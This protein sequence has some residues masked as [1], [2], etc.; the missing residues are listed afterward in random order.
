[1]CLQGQETAKFKDYFIW[2]SAEPNKSLSNQQEWEQGSM[3]NGGNS[4]PE[5]DSL[6]DLKEL[7]GMQSL[8]GSPRTPLSVQQSSPESCELMLCPQASPQGSAAGE[9]PLQMAAMSQRV[10]Y[11]GDFEPTPDQDSLKICTASHANL[12]DTASEGRI[13][14]PWPCRAAAG[15]A[16]ASCKIYAVSHQDVPYGQ[17]VPPVR[18]RKFGECGTVRERLEASDDNAGPLPLCQTATGQGTGKPSDIGMVNLQMIYESLSEP[19]QDDSLKGHSSDQPILHTAAINVNET[20]PSMVSNPAS[21]V[22]ECM[23]TRNQ[24]VQYEDD[25]DPPTEKDLQDCSKDR[26]ALQAAATQDMAFQPVGPDDA[27]TE[28][29]ESPYGHAATHHDV[30]NPEETQHLRG[31]QDKGCNLGPERLQAAALGVEQ[32]PTAQSMCSQPQSDV[33]LQPASLESIGFSSPT[34]I[35]PANLIPSTSAFQA[36]LQGQLEPKSVTPA[37]RFSACNLSEP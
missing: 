17:L 28:N 20:S 35:A 4:Q 36:M 16:E 19:W 1:M 3:Q 34:I 33:V 21:R 24:Q 15:G 14:Q 13:L 30:G 23:K 29:T 27:S 8:D 37:L 2:S 5:G 10:V 9:A 32:S 25:R 26:E 12:Q 7:Q 11:E 31:E 6:S 22:V 18:Q